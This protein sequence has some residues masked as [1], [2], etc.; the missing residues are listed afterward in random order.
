MNPLSNRALS[1]NFHTCALNAHDKSASK[2]QIE[3]RFLF[4]ERLLTHQ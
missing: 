3:Q 1:N 2:I 4:R